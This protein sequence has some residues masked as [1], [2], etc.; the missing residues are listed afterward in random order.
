[1]SIEDKEDKNMSNPGLTVRADPDKVDV[2][3]EKF[4]YGE[5][6]GRATAVKAAIDHALRCKEVS[7]ETLLAQL[8][9]ERQLEFRTRELSAL[10]GISIRTLQR[11]A[12]PRHRKILAR[13]VGRDYVFRFENIKHLLPGV[14]AKIEFIE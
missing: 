6:I 7:T 1:M 12:H 9:Q 8:A 4:S 10:T 2:L 5:K 13:K 3:V 11:W 14:R